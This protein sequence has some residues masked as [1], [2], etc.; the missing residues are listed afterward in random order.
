MSD[1]Q[2]TPPAPSK[3]PK[4]ATTQD[5]EP[6]RELEPQVTKRVFRDAALSNNPAWIQLLGL[7]P[8]LAVSNSLANAL[9]LSA[10][11]LLVVL[12]A[13]A[14]AALLRR[15]IPNYA[16]LPTYLLLIATFT[17]CADQLLE[18]FAFP[19]YAEIALFV[20]IIVTNCM[21]LGRLE[22]VAG[23]NPLGIALRDAAGTGV[24][25]ALALL[26]LGS[27]RELLATGHLG[28][29]LDALLG[30]ALHGLGLADPGLSS[31][32]WGLLPDGFNLPLAALPPG[33][34]LIAGLLLAGG[35]WFQ[36]S[37]KAPA[38]AAPG[39]APSSKAEP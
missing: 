8:L 2:I 31:V 32:G 22:Q 23:R 25:F 17:T 21:I 26:S 4:P 7:C 30:P 24:G 39:A 13:S 38:R 10:A 29:G 1:P 3:T 11:S 34:F 33:A 19:I 16:R 12:G 27:I 6:S 37:T 9:G 14:S 36:L 5:P 35:R 15:W 18:A 20:Q 28:A